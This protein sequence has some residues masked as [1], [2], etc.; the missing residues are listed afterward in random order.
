MIHVYVGHF[1]IRVVVLTAFWFLLLGE[2]EVCI[3]TE[4]KNFVKYQKNDSQGFERKIRN[5]RR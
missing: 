4:G 5:K 1:A 3:K 2:D